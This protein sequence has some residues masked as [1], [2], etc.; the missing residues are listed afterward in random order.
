[1]AP[2]APPVSPALVIKRSV[3]NDKVAMQVTHIP[4]DIDGRKIYTVNGN[5]DQVMKRC[6]DGRNWKPDSRTSWAGYF[7][8]RYRDCRGTSTCPN[9]TCN[10][11]MEYKAVNTT[12][13]DRFGNCRVCGAK[14]F[15]EYCPARKYI[16]LRE[17]AADIYHYGKHTCTAKLIN[18][19]SN[20]VATS[21]ATNPHVKPSEIQGNTLLSAM[22]KRKS[23][24]EIEQ[25]AK[26][27]INRKSISNE[28][29]KQRKVL[30]PEGGNFAAVTQYKEYTDLGMSYITGHIVPLVSVSVYIGNDIC[31]FPK[32]NFFFD[33]LKP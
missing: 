14:G 25:N 8:V 32:K 21:I 13:F 3:W 6:K 15:T 20:E 29:I 17:N 10:F 18:D 16:C 30:Q 11:L 9:S 4:Y 19:V 28:K 26:K 1:M 31:I 12:Q 22:R 5:R 24:E 2:L 7:T 27:M 23:W 33:S